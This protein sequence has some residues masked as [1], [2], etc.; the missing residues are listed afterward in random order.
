MTHAKQELRTAMFSLR[1]VG[2]KIRETRPAEDC[3]EQPYCNKCS[4]PMILEKVSTR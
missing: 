3:K 4:M 1:C 2:C